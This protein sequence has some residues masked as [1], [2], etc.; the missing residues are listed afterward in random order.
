MEANK[1]TKR[2][3]VYKDSMLVRINPMNI[4]FMSASGSY[5]DIHLEKVVIN[6]ANNLSHIHNVLCDEDFLVRVDRSIVVNI[7]KI[8]RI[9]GNMLFMSNGEKLYIGETAIKK[10]K[11][12]ITVIR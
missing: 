10:I 1:E 4:L 8:N 3:F 7:E 2:F 11:S 5:C 6:L 9:A 12:K